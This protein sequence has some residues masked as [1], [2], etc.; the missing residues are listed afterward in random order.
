MRVSIGATHITSN[1][2]K[3]SAEV[4]EKIDQA[5]RETTEQVAEDYKEEIRSGLRTGRKY[6]LPGEAEHIA[7]APGEPPA[8]L[9]HELINSVKTSFPEQAQGKVMVEAW[10][11]RLLEFGTKRFG[12]RPAMRPV[13]ERT[14][15]KFRRLVNKII[16]DSAKAAEVKK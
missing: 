10:Y 7:S 6:K 11:S 2:S 15:P 1:F 14:G 12:A 4:K 3:L 13:M 8:D 16:R 9:T 5:V